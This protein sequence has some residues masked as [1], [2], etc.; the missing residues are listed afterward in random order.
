VGWW[1]ETDKDP[2]TALRLAASLVGL[3]PD[4][5]FD[6]VGSG[7]SEGFVRGAEVRAAAVASPPKM[8]EVSR[9]LWERFSPEAVGDSL[10][11]TYESLTSKSPRATSSAGNRAS[12]Q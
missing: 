1:C 2:L 5:E 9:T 7:P 11:M 8:S 3:L 12:G 10:G 6:M 4:A